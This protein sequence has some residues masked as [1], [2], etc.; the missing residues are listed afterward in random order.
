ML[1]REPTIPKLEL[2]KAISC[3]FIEHDIGCTCTR[4]IQESTRLN[5]C[6]VHRQFSTE[7]F[8]QSQAQ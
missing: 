7:N 4:R 3:D 1:Q 8:T 2:V 5:M 6:V